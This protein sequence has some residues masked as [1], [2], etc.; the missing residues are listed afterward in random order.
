MPLPRRPCWADLYHFGTW[1]TPPTQSSKSNFKFIDSGVWRLRV[2]KIWG[3]PLTLIIAL[4]TVL[5][6]TVLHCDVITDQTKIEEM[7]Q[8]CFHF[9]SLHSFLAFLSPSPWKKAPLNR[10]IVGVS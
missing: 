5:R 8:F 9:P 6:T 4:T 7:R 10:A 3:L 2:P 1:I